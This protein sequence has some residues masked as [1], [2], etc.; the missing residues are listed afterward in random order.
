MFTNRVKQVLGTS[1]VICSMMATPLT[2]D[3]SL[4]LGTV[5]PTERIDGVT[6]GVNPFDNH[7]IEFVN[8]R[9]AVIDPYRS[10]NTLLP[11]DVYDPS[12]QAN[13]VDNI[14]V[15]WG[16]I[17]RM[18]FLD[19]MAG[20]SNQVGFTTGGNFDLTDPVNANSLIF[21]STDSLADGAGPPNDILREHDYVTIFNSSDDVNLD[22]FL[23]QD[24]ADALPADGFTEHVWWTDTAQNSDGARHFYISE[25]VGP[26][27][28]YYYLIAAEDLHQISNQNGVSLDPNDYPIDFTDFVAVVQVVTPEPGTYAM[29]GSFL[30]LVAVVKRRRAQAS[31]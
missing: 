7:A 9:N 27:P 15:P 14:P 13:L 22:L 6:P 23:I 28:Y 24:G 21:P 8:F 4:F 3:D 12:G 2:A 11:Q 5:G 20:F 1:L 10:S 30:A 16:S 26:Y 31:A 18:Y 29:L 17:V 19:E 25:F